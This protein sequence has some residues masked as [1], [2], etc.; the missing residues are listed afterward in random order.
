MPCNKRAE[1]DERK[2][3]GKK[4]GRRRTGSRGER[5]AKYGRWKVQFGRG[6][7]WRERRNAQ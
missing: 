6:A 1:T 2:C 3:R 5:E 7:V 4:R